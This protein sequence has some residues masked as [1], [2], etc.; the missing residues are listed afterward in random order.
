MLIFLSYLQNSWPVCVTHTS[1]A[2]SRME[3]PRSPPQ[4][5]A[6][7][8]HVSVVVFRLVSRVGIVRRRLMHHMLLCRRMD[9]NRLSRNLLPRWCFVQEM[10]QHKKMGR[11]KFDE[12]RCS[13]EK[14]CLPSRDARF[15]SSPWGE[16]PGS[17]D[18][19]PCGAGF[20]GGER[21][22]IK[23]QRSPCSEKDVGG[24]Y[25]V[26][27][28]FPPTCDSCLVDNLLKTLAQITAKPPQAV[29]PCTCLKKIRASIYFCL[30][31]Q[32]N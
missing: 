11:W 26:I 27:P 7:T 15:Y 25:W 4:S 20:Q 22:L 13:D 23:F 24:Q 19:Y 6:S 9:T 31:V 17:G 30:Q 8:L 14:F 10:V 18:I 16:D 12:G 21:P 1:W 32:C 29:F 28:V 3:E 5:D 2:W